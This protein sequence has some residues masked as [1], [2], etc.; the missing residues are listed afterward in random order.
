MAVVQ[1]T[2][3]PSEFKQVPGIGRHCSQK[4]LMLVNA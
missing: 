1:T 3:F 4:E 2:R